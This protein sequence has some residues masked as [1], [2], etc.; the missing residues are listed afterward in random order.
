MKPGDGLDAKS[1]RTHQDFHRQKM[2]SN[3]PTH[4]HAVGPNTAT[5]GYE[6]EI[7]NKENKEQ[8]EAS[9]DEGGNCVASR[10]QST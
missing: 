10:T 8:I 6:G 1:N 3:T 2:K 7:G 4:P 5:D 9:E